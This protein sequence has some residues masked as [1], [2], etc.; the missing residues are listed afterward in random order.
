MVVSHLIGHGVEPAG[1]Y[2]ATPE[3]ALA[4][5]GVRDALEQALSTISPC[6]REAVALRYARGLTY[7][8]MAQVLGCPRKTAESRVRL[9]HQAL[10]R[11][12]SAE[13]RLLLEEL[14]GF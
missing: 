8:E 13:G 3:A 7:R 2:Q 10:R 5:Q 12:L 6:L 1:P 14:W 4:R 11:A 9:A